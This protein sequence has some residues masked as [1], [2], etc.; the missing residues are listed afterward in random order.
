MVVFLWDPNPYLSE[1]RRKTQKIPIDYVD[2]GDWRLNFAF[3][4]Y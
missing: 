2:K 1:F 4:D 3:V